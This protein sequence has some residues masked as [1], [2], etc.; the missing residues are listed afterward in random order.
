MKHPIRFIVLACA[1]SLIS[2][3]TQAAQPPAPLAVLPPGVASAKDVIN[4]NVPFSKFMAQD[5]QVI[6]RNSSGSFTISIPLADRMEIQSAVFHL[7]YTSST[8][9]LDERSKLSVIFNGQNIAQLPLLH[10]QPDGAVDIRLPNALFKHGFNLLTVAVIQHYTLKCEDPAAPELWTQV[11]TLRSTFSLQ[12]RLMPMGGKLSQLGLLF[13]RKSWGRQKI[14]IVTADDEIDSGLKWGA[15][16]AEGAALR[17]QYTPLQVSR[18]TVI[19][20]NADNIVIGTAGEIASLLGTAPREEVAG[21]YIGLMPLPSDPTHFALILSGRTPEEVERAVSTLCEI[22]FPFPDSPSMLVQAMKF[23]VY[24]PYQGQLVA[25]EDTTY[26]FSELGFKTTTLQGWTHGDAAAS[27]QFELNLPP[28]IYAP[29]MSQ[30]EFRLH[31]AHGAGLRG[32]S[33][34]NLFVN[35]VFQDAI[36]LNNVNGASYQGYKIEVPL[37][38]FKPGPN[39]VRFTPSMV[40]Q[41]SDF[42]EIIQQENLLLTLFDDSV[43]KIPPASHFTR[44]PDLQLLN[45]TI[46]PLVSQPAGADLAVQVAAKDSD[47][48]GAAW[49]L[50]AKL[51]QKSAIVLNAATV[52]FDQVSTDR[53]MVVIGSASRIAPEV[54]KAAPFDLGTTNEVAY[55]QPLLGAVIEKTSYLTGGMQ[56]DV[57]GTGGLG[58]LGIA[59]Q[60]RSPYNTN[61]SVLFLSADNP[62]LLLQRTYQLI[63]PSVWSSLQGDVC[64]WNEGDTIASGQMVGPTYDVGSVS[65]NA[66]VDYYVSRNPVYFI[67]AV[68]VLLAILAFVIRSLLSRHKLRHHGKEGTS[69][70]R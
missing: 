50:M 34:F 44:L 27:F 58:T 5:E 62:D 12:G 15:L 63:S 43:V 8:T 38:N 18:S 10:A 24:L 41:F 7:E 13:D 2:T 11:N 37:R 57:E 25:K 55:Q 68:V 3:L 61:K 46:F 23:P 14:N 42:C 16:A 60:F 51:A 49:T 6:L 20:P 54:M 56:A 67:A 45:A 53:N 47:T 28:D 26:R 52:S 64:V 31:F 39:I 21:S 9:L 36:Y 48:I 35:D 33:V 59:M 1:C 69:D 65:V 19:V 40:P 29:E 17:L 32:D 22:N 4:Y 30:V 66:S 70:A